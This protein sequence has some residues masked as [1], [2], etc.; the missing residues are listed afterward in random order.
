MKK[1]P[2]LLFSLMIMIA[3]TTSCGAKSGSSELIDGIYSVTFDEADSTDWKAFFILTVE[4]SK[5]A[6]VNFDYKGFGANEGKLKSE[7]EAYN[8]AMLSATGTNPQRYLNSLEASLMKS[9]DPESVTV[10]SGATTSSNDFFRFAKEA[11]KAAI[12]GNHNPIIIK[13]P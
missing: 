12:D 13:Q 10:I 4:Q 9:G 6:A 2:I 11:I 1:K 7:D 5:I 8:E 3:L